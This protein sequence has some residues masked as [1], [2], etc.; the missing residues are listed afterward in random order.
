[1]TRLWC[2]WRSSALG[3]G[4]SSSSSVV[5]VIQ[6]AGRVRQQPGR[7]FAS[8]PGQMQL[9]AQ[10]DHLKSSRGW[11]IAGQAAGER[12]R[13]VEQAGRGGQ[14]A[15]QVVVIGCKQSTLGFPSMQ[16][17]ERLLLA[18]FRGISVRDCWL[19]L[20]A[21]WLAGQDCRMRED[22]GSKYS[23]IA[24]SPHASWI[25]LGWEITSAVV[26]SSFIQ[27]MSAETA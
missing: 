10:A 16:G 4:G 12:E 24:A 27:S 14:Q 7:R 3:R 6:Q 23:R 13:G 8:L 1:M 15:V 20:L 21:G 18:P 19:C 25:G 5:F 11:C 22:S 9:G 17:A 2:G 26:L